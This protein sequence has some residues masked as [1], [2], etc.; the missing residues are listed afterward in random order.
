MARSIETRC[1]GFVARYAPAVKQVVLRNGQAQ[2]VDVPSPVPA[3]GF[4]LVANA[5]SA[6]SSG[7]ERASVSTDGASLPMRAIRNPALVVRALRYAR[8]H[9]VKQTAQLAREAVSA[10]TPL[11]YSCAGTVLDTGGVASFTVGQ[12]VACAGAGRASH[13]EVASV[14]ANLVVPV[15]DGVS[16]RDASLVAIG[17]IALQGVRRAQAALGER[18]VVIG[19]GLLG[20]LTVQLL[21]ANGCQVLGVEPMERRRRLGIELGAERAVAP[22]EAKT[23]VEEWSNANGADAA[24]V[25]ATSRSSG[26]I[27]QAVEVVRQKGR[28]VPVGDVGL[29][30]ERG[31]LYAREADVLIS[32][33]YGPGRYD[34]S[35]EEEGL[36][37]PLAYVRWTEGRNMEEF[38]R[39]VASGVVRIDPLVDVEVAVEEAS[40]AYAAL[41][42]AEP[43]LVAVLTYDHTGPA[44]E[45]EE[46]V[47]ARAP[48]PDR[49]GLIVV[50]VVG[51]GSFVR[52]MHLRNLKEDQHA[53]IKWVV[54]RRGTS[55]A[56][57]ARSLPEAEAATDWQRVIDDLE[58]ELVLVGT[59]HDTHAE[60]AAA[61][62]RAGKAVFLEK[63]LGLSRAEIDDVWAAGAT[64]PSLVI[65]FNRPL[66][67]LASRLIEEVREAE[68][69]T[70]LGYRVSAP[71]EAEHWL[72]DPREGGGRI[73]GEACHM[74]DFANAVC[75]TPRRVLAAALPAPPGVT[76]VESA[77]VT[78]QYE[79]G[80]LATVLY[81]GVGSPAMPKERVEVLRG[82]RSWV[83]DDFLTLTSFDRGDPS[84]ETE[85]RQDKGH[86]RL[87]A[88]VLAACRGEAPFEPGLRAA[89]VA[90]SVG[91]AALESIAAG[92]PTEVI[93]PPSA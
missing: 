11:G 65:G 62:L 18:V 36:D 29:D 12:R 77:S 56:E 15:P 26:V 54:G 72:N 22:D 24:I 37:Y 38:L 59:R 88:R 71:L 66:A 79:D 86:A 48:K 42:E 70:H 5:A 20:L 34:R 78:I 7:T 73:L 33:S 60:I 30:L 27:N 85:R 1:V 53:T 49:E 55:A 68:G 6:I 51:A 13:A 50:A 40:R 83:L 35:Y 82:G 74:F 69:P 10:E 52:S 28:V 45:H 58:V 43:P 31:P 19:L 81:S 61:A 16:L 39:L 17:A 90:Q 93:L 25:T 9:G 14:P 41:S 8:E 80:S 46:P 23:A 47:P 32:T 67:P 84:T 63:P 44:P 76:T 21:R 3:P 92:T 91:L 64:D 57:L 4:V 87:L 2:V 89:Y 75:G